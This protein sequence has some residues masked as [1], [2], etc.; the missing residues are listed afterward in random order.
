MSSRK[1]KYQPSTRGNLAT[2]TASYWWHE[3][4]TQEERDRLMAAF[5]PALIECRGLG[6]MGVIE[7]AFK[8][9]LFLG[10]VMDEQS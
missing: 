5:Q 4:L 6:D 3:E 1:N 10:E 9:F 8:L 7:L 2:M